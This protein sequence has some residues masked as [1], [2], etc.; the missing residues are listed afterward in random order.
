MA[1]RK[2]AQAI[3]KTF[4][5]QMGKPVGSRV[6]RLVEGTENEWFKTFFDGFGAAEE[7]KPSK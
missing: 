5:E 1:E 7:L 4:I 6:F 2:Y 3:G